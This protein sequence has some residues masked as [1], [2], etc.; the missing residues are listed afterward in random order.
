MLR[1]IFTYGGVLLLTGAVLLAMPGSSRAQ[2]GGGH[3]GGG[4]G[5][6]AHFGGYHGGGA[7]FGGYHIG[8][9]RFGS[10]RSGY[11]H[12]GYHPYY[13][14]YGFYNYY[15][16]TYGYYPYSSGYYPY[17]DTYPY[18]G[19]DLTYNSAYY[20]LYGG[21]TPSYPGGYAATTEPAASYSTFSL[22]GTGQPDAIANAVTSTGRPDSIAHV[23]VKVPSGARVWFDDTPT[24]STGSTRL[25]DSPPLTPG[26]RYNYA[27]RARWNQNGQEVTQTKQVEVT[28][29]S[30]VNVDFSHSP[31]T[32]GRAATAPKS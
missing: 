9:Y 19:S 12:Y 13:H 31:K 10:Y 23:A 18:G 1:H 22:S 15:P 24:R 4:H 30:H 11:D 26:Q 14:H 21:A 29:G 5:G 3:F 17:F 25:F 2:H 32:A 8:G 20:G 28:A 27:I 6:G 16:Y 7:R